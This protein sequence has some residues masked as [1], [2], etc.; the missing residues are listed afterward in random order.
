[1]KRAD[2]S[3]A[4][5]AITATNERAHGRIPLVDTLRTNLRARFAAWMTLIFFIAIALYGF[6]IFGTMNVF[7]HAS[8]KDSL[9]TQADVIAANLNIESGVMKLPESLIEASETNAHLAPFTARLLDIQGRVLL[10]S[11]PASGAIPSIKA[12]PSQSSFQLID[13]DLIVYT[14]SILDNDTALAILQVAQSTKSLEKTLRQLLLIMIAA[15]AIFLPASAA[16]G[17]FLAVRL[18]RPIDIMTRTA[19]RFSA[20]AL[21]ARISL[22]HTDDELGRLAATFDEMLDRVELSFNRYKQFTADASHEL[23]TPVSVMR[24]ILSVTTRRTRTAEEYELAMVDLGK[25]VDRLDTLV[26]DLLLLSRADLM[27]ASLRDEIDVGSLLSGMV[28][29]LRPLAVHKGLELACVIHD[30]VVTHGDGD[31]L[32]HAFMNVIDNAIKY[33]DK[34]SILVALIR[35]G[36]LAKITIAD[37]GIGIA[38]ADISR[39][40]DRFMRL[41]AARSAPGTGLGLAIAKAIIAGHRGSIS[42]ISEPGKGTEISILLPLI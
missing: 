1:M 41:E 16:G 32:L 36:S 21:S 15:L 42:A 12:P 28:E 8:M 13:P 38:A 26:A 2:D 11:G 18:L 6:L 9:R 39:I 23:R 25:A 7:L 3:G 33:T 30:T 10:E 24:A 35:N 19:R 37:T 17:Y 34:G 4:G 31:A 5:T 22:P 14:T 40:F 20:E 29:S 27:A